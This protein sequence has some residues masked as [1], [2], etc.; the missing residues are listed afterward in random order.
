VS[1]EALLTG[2]PPPS[3]WCPPYCDDE[4]I[5]RIAGGVG[6]AVALAVLMGVPRI[7]GIETWKWALGLAGLVL[8][9]SGGLSDRRKPR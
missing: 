8:F 6:V 7:G 1:H 2:G 9:V 4:M 5:G 3:I